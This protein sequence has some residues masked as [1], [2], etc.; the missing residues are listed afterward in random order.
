MSVKWTTVDVWGEVCQSL[1][2]ANS[3][4]IS[5]DNEVTDWQN[6][7]SSHSEIYGEMAQLLVTEMNF[8]NAIVYFRILCLQRKNIVK[9]WK[10]T[11]WCLCCV[12]PWITFL[13]RR[14]LSHQQIYHSYKW[15]NSIFSVQVLSVVCRSVGI[16][17]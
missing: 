2:N 13:S 10:R 12:F 14:Q 4:W 3:V 11:D 15:G 9:N 5:H 7:S 17:Y 8:E 6:H 1:K 16:S